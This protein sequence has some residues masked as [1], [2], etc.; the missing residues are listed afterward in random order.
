MIIGKNENANLIAMEN[1]DPEGLKPYQRKRL[2]NRDR[3][4][5]ERKTMRMHAKR[6]GKEPKDLLAWKLPISE[7]NSE[8]EESFNKDIREVSGEY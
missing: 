4:N 2:A 6:P 8:Q 5:A 1:E 3:V 7:T